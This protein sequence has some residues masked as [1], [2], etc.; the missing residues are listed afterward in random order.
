MVNSC[1]SSAGLQV[2]VLLVNRELV[3]GHL[4][5]AK[6]KLLNL[7]RMTIKLTIDSGQLTMNQKQP[8]DN[9]MTTELTTELTTE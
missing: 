6:C 4:Q 2:T 9:R 7:N 5:I 3:N 8:N 1:L